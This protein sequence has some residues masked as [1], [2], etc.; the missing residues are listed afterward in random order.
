M[1]PAQRGTSIPFRVRMDGRPATA[2]HGSDVD[3]DASGLVLEQRTYQLIRQAAPIVERTFEIEFL[4]AGVEVFCFT[5][6]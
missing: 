2:D 5:F 4:D 6:G 1:G 3:A